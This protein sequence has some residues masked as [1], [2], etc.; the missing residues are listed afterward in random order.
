MTGS[1]TCYGILRSVM[2][3][4]ALASGS[5]PLK[6]AI[7]TTLIHGSLVHVFFILD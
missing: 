4:Q 7:S 2:V 3:E 1:G 6:T 5:I